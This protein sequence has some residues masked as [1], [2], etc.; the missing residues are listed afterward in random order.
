MSPHQQRLWRAVPG[1]LMRLL[2]DH[3]DARVC[4]RD[5][6]CIISLEGQLEE[7]SHRGHPRDNSSFKNAH[8]WL[9]WGMQVCF[10]NFLLI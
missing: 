5:K 8:Q 1:K 4:A 3:V 2:Q 6:K 9:H 10:Y 7:C